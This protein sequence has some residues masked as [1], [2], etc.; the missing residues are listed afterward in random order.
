MKK[1]KNS[2]GYLKRSFTFENKRYYV[3]GK[4]NT[5]LHEKET[6]KRE[7]LEQKFDSRQNPILKEYYEKRLNYK[8]NSIIQS[9]Y[10]GLESSKNVVC[11]IYIPSASRK[12]GELPIKEVTVDD[13]MIVQDTLSSTHQTS[14][15][16]WHMAKLK[17][18]FC[19]ALTERILVYNPFDLISSLK[20]TEETA[21]D[22]YHRALTIE[23]QERFFN[24]ELT[25]NN[26]FYNIFCFA[27]CT[28][29]RLGE[30]GALKYK[31]VTSDY[32]I[33]QRTLTKI[34]G[35]TYKV[36]DDTKTK[37]GKRMIP[38]NNKIRDVLT[39]Q[40]E[41]NIKR[42][43]EIINLDNLMFPSPYGKLLRN[44]YIN[45]VLKEICE[46]EGIDPFTMHAF[47]DTFATRAIENNMNPRM[48]QSILGHKDYG[49]TMNLYCHTLPE[50]LIEEMNK[51]VINI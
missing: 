15:V 27:I 4:N 9:T 47:R 14:T 42:Y 35:G 12:F 16:N 48:L 49:M 8:K 46:A 44:Q 39:R 26:N 7:E 30:I 1:K 6:K 36:G 22:T 33:V 25:K 19:D 2:R 31:D 29:M 40:K 45:G 34:S 41:L 23:E 20:R 43:G 10:I 24:S 11:D 5:E 17:R 50:T 28:G 13:L 32:I 38:I 3:Y 18:I 51:V 21:R 37:A